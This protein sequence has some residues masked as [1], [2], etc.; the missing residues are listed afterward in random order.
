MPS[1][2]LSITMIGGALTGTSGRM[3]SVIV[4]FGSSALLILITLTVSAVLSWTFFTL[5]VFWATGMRWIAN[6]ISNASI[7]QK[8][9]MIL[10]G[11]ILMPPLYDAGLCYL[12]W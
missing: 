3:R 2:S 6:I 12:T 11:V 9:I 10:N 7:A 8:P 5:R 4:G 1:S